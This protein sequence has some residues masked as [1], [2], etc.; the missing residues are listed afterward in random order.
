ME[1]EEAK[2]DGEAAAEAKADGEAAEAEAEAAPAVP[3]DAEIGEAAAADEG[4]AAVVSVPADEPVPAAA[5][6]EEPSFPEPRHED[7]AF[8][9]PECNS[10]LRKAFYQ[11]C[12]AAFLSCCAQLFLA[13]HL[14]LVAVHLILVS[15]VSEQEIRAT[16]PDLFLN[17]AAGNN[18]LK[19]IF[20]TLE[21]NADSKVSS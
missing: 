21:A 3:Q 15:P 17:S 6:E 12:S 5:K 13:D 1:V 18:K 2:A 14:I 4:A 11:A 7:N 19:E 9:I 10:F 16:H 20:V 8:V